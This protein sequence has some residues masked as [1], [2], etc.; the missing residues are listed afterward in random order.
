MAIHAQITNFNGKIDQHPNKCPRCHALIQA[1]PVYGQQRQQKDP[2]DIALEIAYLCG[3]TSCHRLFV[4]Q[5]YRPTT[6]HD[7]LLVNTLPSDEQKREFS[8]VLTNISENFVLIYNEAYAAEQRKLMQI[9][10][11]GYRKALEFL[12]KDYLIQQ[13]PDD[14]D[15]IRGKL[16][17]KCI[18]DHL[19]SERIKG[20][21]K[22]AVWLGNDETHY[23]RKW[24]DKDLT[25]LK[26]LIDLS[27]HWIESEELTK[28]ALAAMPVGK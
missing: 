13:K 14:A 22:R 20:V 25:D 26:R 1:H 5:F 10:G 11:V 8:A 6:Q 23:V 4:G 28:E 21:A 15:V 2:G 18:D 24:E 9:C 16:L 12:I 27:A 19:E 17:G 7:F 3:N